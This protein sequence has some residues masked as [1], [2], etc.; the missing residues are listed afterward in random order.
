MLLLPHDKIPINDFQT[1]S[2]MSYRH[3]G[4]ELVGERFKLIDALSGELE[5]VFAH[6]IQN[7]LQ[8]YS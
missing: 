2:S 6:S 3:S 8:L 4:S 1:T 5:S 7:L